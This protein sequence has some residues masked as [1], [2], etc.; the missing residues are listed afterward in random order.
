MNKNSPNSAP[1]SSI[2]FYHLTT[3]PLEN[4]LPKLLEK[5]L[6]GGYRSLV[7]VENEL[8]MEQLNTH[9]WNYSADSFLPHGSVNDEKI[10]AQ[11]ILLSA[12]FLALNTA[13]LL[14]ITNGIN[15]LENEDKCPQNYNK[16]LDI[17]DGNDEQKISAA[18]LRWT[19]Y[20]A[21]G[22]ELSYFQQ[23][24]QGGWQKK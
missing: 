6:A 18:R 22:Y 23:T 12:D 21:A 7:L 3:T 24:P 8:R 9:L 10:E 15:L 5:A 14:V 16:V 20:K 13:N 11:P 17:F 19:A 4:A 2:N 1:S